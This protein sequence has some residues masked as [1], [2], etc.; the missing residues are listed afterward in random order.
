MAQMGTLIQAQFDHPIILPDRVVTRYQRGRNE[1]QIEFSGNRYL[2]VRRVKGAKNFK[3]AS[4]IKLRK[5]FS[6]NFPIVR[7]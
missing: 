6:L 3:S 4:C 5:P 2:A 7:R 1:G